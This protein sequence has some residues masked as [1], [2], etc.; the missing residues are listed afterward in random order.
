M[1]RFN[2]TPCPGV[3]CFSHSKGDIYIIV[4]RLSL[5][6]TAYIMD[7]GLPVSA[8]NLVGGKKKTDRERERKS[9]KEQQY[10]PGLL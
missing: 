3:S 2:S 9:R 7:E 10:R 1:A 5:Y 6:N 8:E 4:Q